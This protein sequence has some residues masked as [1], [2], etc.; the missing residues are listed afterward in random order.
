MDCGV[1]KTWTWRFL[2]ASGAQEKSGPQF[3]ARFN[4]QVFAFC[5]RAGAAAATVAA[6]PCAGALRSLSVLAVFVAVGAVLELS[7]FFAAMGRRSSRMSAGVGF[8][9]EPTLRF[10]PS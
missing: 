2:H 4:E 3:A 5:Q 7:S 10:M 8:G 1:S 9:A 6:G